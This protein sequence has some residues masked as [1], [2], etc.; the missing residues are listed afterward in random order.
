M[1]HWIIDYETLVNCTVFC[2]Q[3]Y[4]DPEDLRV[5][6]IGKK[7]NDLTKLVTFLDQTVNN[8]EFHISFNGN[9]FD[10]LITNYIMN[11]VNS[12]EIS[13]DG[14][15]MAGMIYEE[16]QKLIHNEE[17]LG[18]NFALAKINPVRSID[19][20]KLNHWD[21]PAKR[22]S[23]KWIQYSMDW[24]NI[25]EMPIHHTTR[26]ETDE[27]LDTVIQYCINDV[28]STARIYELSKNQI[29]LRKSLTGE[30]NIDLF[31]SSEPRIS[32]MLFSYFLSKATGISRYDLT[33]LRTHREYIYVKDIILPYIKF[34]RPEFKEILIKFNEVII[35]TANTKGGFKC[36]MIHKNV[37]T[38]FGLGGVHGATSSGIY[39]AKDGMIIMT[40]DVTSFYPNLAIKNRWSPAH[41]PQ[42]EFCDQY[43]WFFEER[44]KI[45]KKDPRNY[46]YKII[47][48]STYGLSNDKNSFLYDPEFTMRIT[49]NGQLSLMMLYEM[50]SEGIPGSIPIMQN[51]DGLEMMIPAHYKD[52]YLG[53][54]AEWEKLTMLSLEHDQYSKLI[55]ADVNNYIAV[56]K[57][58]ECSRE[59]WESLKISSP[60]YVFSSENNKYYYNAT[61]CKG[62]F[63][64]TDLA[65]H[66]N[67]SFLIIPK[68]IYYYF[69]HQVL[70]EH[71]LRDN[72]NIFDY[73]AGVKIKGDWEFI[74]TCVVDFKTYTRK[75]QKIVRYYM[76]NVGCKIVKRNYV[77]GREIQ[78]ES[79]R[80]HQKVFNEYVDK[81]WEEYDIDEKY[82]LDRIYKEIGN[83][84][85]PQEQYQLTLF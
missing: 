81:P 53:I 77:D 85:K 2:A 63:E 39:E 42:E 24:Y 58:K 4:K 38:D 48:N 33:Q 52:K 76:S 41:L 1:N 7:R 59:E 55:L 35:N 32:K 29:A 22:S 26:I 19:L 61:K 56:H 21:N 43:E 6:V 18:N 70:P 12:G 40:S 36:S 74:E 11:A 54:C 67:K 10:N 80:C 51:T 65:L 31:S 30:Y 14:E 5:F 44:K 45:P 50:L 84:T 83:I 47:L 71:F 46:V 9:A 23:L 78:T 66:K 16:A 20:Y 68:A 34:K 82:Y 37:K 28:K 3:H 73:C 64:I 75:L 17:I 62:R 49:I 72:R 27:Q 13:H 57:T 25:Q 79:G 60:H 69:V 8:A 15:I